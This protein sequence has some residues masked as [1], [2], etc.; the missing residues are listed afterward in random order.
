MPVLLDEPDEPSSTGTITAAG[1]F[2]THAYSP[3]VPSARSVV[4]SWSR[5]QRFS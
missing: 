1:G 5:I 2:S 3:G 4:S